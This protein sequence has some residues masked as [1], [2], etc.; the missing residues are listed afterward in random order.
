MSP[1]LFWLGPIP[2]TSF[3]F[4]AAMGTLLTFLAMSARAKQEEMDPEVVVDI[5]LV[6]LIT[7]FLGARIMFVI[8]YPETVAGDPWAFLKIWSGGLTFYGGLIGAVLGNFLYL[9][10]KGLPALDVY[11]LVFPFV[12]IGH[13]FGRVGCFGNGCCYGVPVETG[14]G[15]VFHPLVDPQQLPRHATQLY[16]AFGLMV[17]ALILNRVWL[18]GFRGGRVTALYLV[19]YAFLRF[20]LEFFR[21]DTLSES[22]LFGTTLAQTTAMVLT[23]L[24]AVIW[25]QRW[26]LPRPPLGE[27]APIEYEDDEEDQ[28]PDGS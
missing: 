27:W 24:A 28:E 2:I 8:T 6:F 10:W 26:P 23:A 17:I 9:R 22:Y 20:L 13:A 21:G 19:L 14:W 15:W 7:G 12:A 16:E 4:A 11:D 1:I 18:R 5:Y 25:S 3:G